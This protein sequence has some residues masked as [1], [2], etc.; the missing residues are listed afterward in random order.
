M[1]AP[2]NAERPPIITA[3][4]VVVLDVG[5]YS[6]GGVLPISVLL[7]AAAAAIWQLSKGGNIRSSRRGICWPYNGQLSQ[8]GNLYDEW[9]VGLAG[10]IP[11]EHFPTFESEQLGNM[12]VYEG[13]KL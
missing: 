11:T 9:T 1:R 8:L 6:L 3:S 5:K 2:W 10:S 12:N 7:S 13:Q 4:F